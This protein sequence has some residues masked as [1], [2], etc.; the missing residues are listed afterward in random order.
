MVIKCLRNLTSKQQIEI[1]NQYSE[2]VIEG[3]PT[4]KLLEKIQK[5]LQ[6]DIKQAMQFIEV[7]KD[8]IAD[9][10]CIHN[11][12]IINSHI[13][14]YEDVYYRF[15]QLGHLQGKLQSMKQ[16]EKLLGLFQD[17]DL[18][19]QTI[20]IQNNIIATEKPQYNIKQLDKQQQS[21]LAQLLKVVVPK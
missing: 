14:I 15:K 3:V 21:R 16:K 10:T 11:E 19:E 7:V 2:L 1:I 18:V 5:E 13:A 20:N 9:V 8:N 6:C 12:T 4:L 17:D